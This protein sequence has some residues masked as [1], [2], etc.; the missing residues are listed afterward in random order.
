MLQAQPPYPHNTIISIECYVYRAFK[1]CFE[2]Q[3]ILHVEQTLSAFNV[4]LLPRLPARQPS[5]NLEPSLT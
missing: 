5:E 3:V 4:T 1:A 2:F